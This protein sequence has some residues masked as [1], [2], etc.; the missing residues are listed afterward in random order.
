MEQNVK[1]LENFL[2]ELNR[3]CDSSA[4]TDNWYANMQKRLADEQEE[5]RIRNDDSYREQQ[6]SLKAVRDDRPDPQ[7]DFSENGADPKRNR[8]KLPDP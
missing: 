6:N 1:F 5:K 2:K 4:Q 3:Y 7:A 8:G